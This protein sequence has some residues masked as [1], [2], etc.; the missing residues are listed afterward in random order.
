[1]AQEVAP[2]FPEVAIRDAQTGFYT[3]DYAKLVSPIIKAFQE[4]KSEF[5]A[6][7]STL[8]KLKADNDKLRARVATLEAK[9]K[10]Q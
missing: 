2:L 6:D 10:Q 8:A 7:H 4:F 1:V 5:D 3:L 9:S